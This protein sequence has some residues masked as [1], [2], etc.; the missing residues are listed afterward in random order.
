MINSSLVQQMKQRF[1]FCSVSSAGMAGGLSAANEYLF[2]DEQGF[3]LKQ[4]RAS[5]I[6][7]VQRIELVTAHLASAAIAVV[8]AIAGA[9][10]Q[11]HFWDQGRIYALFPRIF[12]FIRHQDRL[13]DYAL[14]QAGA[15]L[16]QIHSLIPPFLRDI[17]PSLEGREAQETTDAALWAAITKHPVDKKIDE[18]ARAL[19]RLKDDIIRHQSGCLELPRQRQT[20]VHGDYHNENLLFGLDDSLVAVLDL[21]LTSINDYMIDL[22]SF[23]HLGCCNSGYE[24]H[25]LQKAAAF[26]AGYRS[27][28]DLDEEDFCRGMQLFIKRMALSRFIEREVYFA[29]R[30]TMGP[31][32]SRDLWRLRHLQTHA[33]EVRQRL[34]Q[35]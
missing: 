4:Y 15:N 21:E 29:Q 23:I 2:A 28:R 33:H 32:L 19:L 26:M 3:V 24:E 9:D 8:Q 25:N 12:G 22:M 30:Q 17:A 27:L 14:F 13:T 35:R 1:G 20:L 7:T 34:Q 18:D 31:L 10:G 5:D 6:V 11:R 16:A